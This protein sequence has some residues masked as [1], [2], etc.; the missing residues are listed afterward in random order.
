MR[1]LMAIMF[2]VVGCL[3]A[4]SE[5]RLEAGRRQS[6]HVD[7]FAP[8]TANVANSTASL[9]ERKIRLKFCLDVPCPDTKLNIPE[10]YCCQT[11]P[12]QPC[13]RTKDDC[14]ARC[15]LCD[16]M[17]PPPPPAV[18]ENIVQ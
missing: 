1:Y 2:L 8:G 17:C 11:L 16:P 13:F 9:D 4:M 5:C 14:N 18:E 7:M 3:A 10:C 6:S 15:P 12:G